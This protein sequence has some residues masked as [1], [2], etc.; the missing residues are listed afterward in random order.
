MVQNPLPCMRAICSAASV[1]SKVTALLD[2]LPLYRVLSAVD[3]A[4]SQSAAS[5]AATN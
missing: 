2:E 5:P 3:R 1:I 4:L